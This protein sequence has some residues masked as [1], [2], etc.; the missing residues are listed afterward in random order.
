[1]LEDRRLIPLHHVVLEKSVVKLH[2]PEVIREHQDRWLTMS[3][4][5]HVRLGTELHDG[6][7][8]FR[9]SSLNFF[10]E[11]KRMEDHNITPRDT[12]VIS[13]YVNQK[14]TAFLATVLE[15]LISNKVYGFKT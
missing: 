8:I 2:L 12:I 3:L 6:I 13:Y 14:P 11:R 10:E 15:V 5:G 7:R 1:M 9:K 4:I